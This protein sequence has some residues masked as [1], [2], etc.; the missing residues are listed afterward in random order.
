[1]AIEWVVA[2]FLGAFGGHALDNWLGTKPWFFLLGF[3]FGAAAGFL[4]VVRLV[5]SEKIS[6]KSLSKRNKED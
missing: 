6:H 2:L 3:L 5:T 1:M 4:N